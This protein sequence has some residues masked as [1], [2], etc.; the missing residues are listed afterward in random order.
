[1]RTTP[2]PVAS[3]LVLLEPLTATLLAWLLF[4]ER[5]SAVGI[6]G[7]VLL[8]AAIGLLSQDENKRR[9]PKSVSER[10]EPLQR[11]S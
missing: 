11:L 1:M 9:T 3:V 2:A 6:G 4:D 7:A 8:L 10:A 5:L